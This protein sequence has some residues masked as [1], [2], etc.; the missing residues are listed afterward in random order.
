MV[1]VG[2]GSKRHF[3][4]ASTAAFTNTGWPPTA[5][6]SVTVPFGATAIFTFTVPERFNFRASYGYTGST[7]TVARCLISPSS[8]ARTCETP[9]PAAI[10]IAASNTPIF[11]TNTQFLLGDKLDQAFQARS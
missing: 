4:A 8:P 2:V 1:P 5:F 6:A 7:L 9:N 11:R 10:A 3:L